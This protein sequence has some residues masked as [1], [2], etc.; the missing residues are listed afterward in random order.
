MDRESA[1]VPAIVVLPAEIDVTNCDSVAKGLTGPI[2]TA[3]LVIVDM[4]GTVFCDSTGIQVLLAAHQ[5]AMAAGC[6]LRVAVRPSGSVARVLSIVGVDRI[7]AIYA[8]VAEALP[9]DS[10]AVQLTG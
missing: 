3:T 6:S 10:A 8:S 7:L 2:E 4:T 5:R 9:A 1:G